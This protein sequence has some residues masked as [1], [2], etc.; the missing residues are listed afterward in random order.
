[1][2][3]PR[4]QLW[5]ARLMLRPM[6]AS[7]E[8]AVVAGL[9]DIAVSGW[10]AVVPHPYGPLDFAEFLP[11]AMP[12]QAFVIEDRIGFA[13][14]IS[15]RQ[16]LGY[17]LAP[18]VHGQGYATE[19]AR[20][21]LAEYFACGSD[22]ITSGYF[23]GNTR[24]ARVLSKLGFTETARATKFCRALGRDRPHV[25]LILTKED[26]QRAEAPGGSA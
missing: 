3:M 1:M 26:Y 21:V 6:V 12:G 25:A 4:A 24:S 10:L 2:A 19:A 11:K 23:E 7:D 22:P 9:N 5:T 18:A 13:G 20:A 8:P 16:A 14:V 17:W 15:V